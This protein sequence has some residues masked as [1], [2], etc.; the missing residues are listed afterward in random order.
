MTDKAG[1]LNETARTAD[2]HSDRALPGAMPALILLLLINMFNYIDRYVLVAV[3]PAIRQHFFGKDDDYAR[4]KTGGLATAFLVS[5]MIA[6]PLFGRMADRMKRWPLVGIS[7]ILW[8]LASGASGLALTFTA[9]LVTRM[10]VGIGEAGYGPSAPTIISDLYPVK[11][12]GSVLAWFY[13]A[14]PVGSAVGYSL[15]GFVEDHWG[16]RAAFYVVVLPGLFLGMWCFLM[17]EPARG[18]ADLT[19]TAHRANWRDYPVLLRSP[20]YLL[21]T[22][23]MIALTFAIGGISYWMPGYL[24]EFRQV[25]S[26]GDVN[27]KFGVIAMVAGVTATLFG[28]FVGDLLRTR[29]PGAY[30]VVSACGI[31]ISCP[32]V[33]MILWTPFPAAWVVMFFAMFFLFFNTGPSNTILA[34]VTHPSVRATAFAFNIFIIHLLGDAISPTLL[35]WIIGGGRGTAHGWRMAFLTVSIVMA[36]A[37]ALWMWGAKYL[38]RDTANAPRS[39]GN[40][41]LH[42]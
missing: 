31:W 21:D 1:C 6:S 29:L 3:E 28:G 14:I 36:V 25:G 2:A 12:R 33:L 17:P 32:L 10:F 38:D 8:S 11:K 18:Q 13:M 27:F 5:Y 37:G 24:Q 35:G 30:F 42:N 22:A 39:V 34:N 19:S 20:S 7:V 4:A 41:P 26:L 16:W 15:G 23:G 9:L 40:Q